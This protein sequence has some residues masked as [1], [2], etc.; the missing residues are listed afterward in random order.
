MKSKTGIFLV[1][2][3]SPDSY[4]PAD[5]KEYLREF[6]LDEKVIDLP[7][8][9]RKF[10]V[11]GIILNIRPKESGEAYEAIW[12]ED[13]S[14]L[15]VISNRVLIK[16]R[17]KFG[18]DIPISLGMRYGNPSIKSGIEDL[19]V[20]NPDLEEVFL[21]PLYPQY[22]MATTETVTERT[23]E[24]ISEF[25]PHLKLKLKEPFFN[26]PGYIQALGESMKPHLPDDL[27]HLLFS[28]HGVPERHIKKRDI[29][30]NHCL[31]FEN[32]CENTSVA[33]AFCYRH[34]DLMTTKQVAA[35]LDLDNKSYTYSNAFQSKL[36]IDPWLSPATDKE[37]ERLAKE[38]K[39]K[40]AVVC[41][42]FISDCIETLEEIGIR[43]EEEFIEAGGEE[44]VLIPCIN[45]H[46]LWIDVLEAWC[47][48]VLSNSPIHE[49]I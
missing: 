7:K 37:L 49:A 34:Q 25:F 3:G 42:A 28:Y 21:I 36:G 33:H 23:K 24:V 1:N 27:D 39:K 11:E 32:C 12:W 38:G 10:L 26:D 44:L 35:Y 22:A 47:N 8:P 5:V 48:E 20:Q 15:I 17:S 43:G 29:T 13:G 14:P 2:L 41:P 4:E 46:D 45:D 40:V 9:L 31:K 18:A 30:G 6:L 19:L 16:L